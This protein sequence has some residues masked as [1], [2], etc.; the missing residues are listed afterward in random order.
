MTIVLAIFMFKYLMDFTSE[1]EDIRAELYKRAQSEDT[2]D[3]I[4][5]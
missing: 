4:F 1:Y 5:K 2:S 3:V